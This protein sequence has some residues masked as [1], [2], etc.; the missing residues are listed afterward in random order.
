MYRYV[1]NML[2]VFGSPLAISPLVHH[3]RSTHSSSTG[4]ILMHRNAITSSMHHSLLSPS[5]KT[6]L[7]L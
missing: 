3:T 7:L 5:P 4:V 1:F 6:S 2:T